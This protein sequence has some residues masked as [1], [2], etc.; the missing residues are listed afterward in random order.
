MAEELADVITRG[1][2]RMGAQL[3]ER[4]KETIELSGN[5]IRMESKIE[6]MN[7]T[8]TK[9]ETE[10]AKAEN[11]QIKLRVENLETANKEVKNKQS[12]NAR[13][14]K[15]LIASVIL[16]LVGFLLNFLRIGFK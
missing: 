3:R 4:E 2:E 8:L 14:M 6:V 7:A 1:F 16:L 9:V 15:G 10:M 5:M 13:W 11:I 12:E